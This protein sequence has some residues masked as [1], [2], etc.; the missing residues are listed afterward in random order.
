MS[1]GK[2]LL[3]ATLSKEEARLIREGHNADIRKKPDHDYFDDEKD[4]Q[5]ERLLFDEQSAKDLIH[6]PLPEEDV[7]TLLEG[8]TMRQVIAGLFLAAKSDEEGELIAPSFY[9]IVRDEV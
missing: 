8:F 5:E 2:T 1:D 9:K 7:E 3:S 4:F 6:F